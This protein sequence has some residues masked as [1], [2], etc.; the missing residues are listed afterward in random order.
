MLLHLLFC[1]DLHFF[2][3]LN[4]LFALAWFPMILFDHK[5]Y[6]GPHI[7]L[8]AC[9]AMNA[10]ILHQYEPSIV[11]PITSNCDCVC[12]VLLSLL[13]L[14]VILFWYVCSFY[15]IYIHLLSTKCVNIF[16]F[17]SSHIMS[18]N[19]VAFGKVGFVLEVKQNCNYTYISCIITIRNGIFSFLFI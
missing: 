14:M 8:T 10:S 19:Y 9:A 1:L 18:L 11:W 17:K 7:S 6:S 16:Y 13:I 5:L 4:I 15:I 2:S 3:C 12:T